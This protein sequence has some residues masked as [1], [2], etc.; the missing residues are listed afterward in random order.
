[1][2]DDELLRAFKQLDPIEPS[3]RFLAA[4][5]S[6]PLTHPRSEAKKSLSLW[7]LFGLPSRLATLGLSALLGVGAG[8]FTLDTE[9]TDP[10]L[11]A[12]LALDSNDTS[13]TADTTTDWGLE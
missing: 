6:V 12:F 11:S 3:P 1:M 13:S 9:P 7:E 2:N 5:R 4:V 8:Y 10:E